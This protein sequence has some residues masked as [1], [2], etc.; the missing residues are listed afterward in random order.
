MSRGSDDQRKDFLVDCEATLEKERF[1]EG[2]DFISFDFGGHQHVL[3]LAAD[4][5][6]VLAN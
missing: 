2:A 5:V 4:G 6:F 3:A 1:A